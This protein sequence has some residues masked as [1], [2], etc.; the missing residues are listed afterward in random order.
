MTKTEEL[1]ETK[2]LNVTKTKWKKEL[3]I[4]LPKYFSNI[5]MIICLIK[6]LECTNDTNAFFGFI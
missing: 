6:I 4:N 3:I 5:E 2:P 1:E